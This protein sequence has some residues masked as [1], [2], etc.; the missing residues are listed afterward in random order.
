MLPKLLWLVWKTCPRCVQEELR[1]TF[2][3]PLKAATLNSV[4]NQTAAAQQVEL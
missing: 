4:L 3:D 1:A 2:C